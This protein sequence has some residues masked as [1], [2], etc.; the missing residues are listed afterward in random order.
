MNKIYVVGIGPGSKDNL[1]FKAHRILEEADVIVGYTEYVKL[2]KEYLPEKEYLSTPMTKEIDRV[3]LLIKEALSGKKAVMISSG[4]AG[5]YAMAGLV[6]ELAS[7]YDELEVEVVPGVPATHSAAAILG[8]PIIH[9]FAT[10]SLSDLLT[11]WED[12]EKRLEAAASSDFVVSLY[13]PGSKKRKT[14]LKRAA[15]IMLKYRP[16]DT[17]CAYIKRID[18]EGEEFGYITLEDLVSYEADMFTTIIIGKSTTK[19]IKNQMVTARG[20]KI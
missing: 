6:I 14:H 2:V 17:V 18:R 20:Y 3:K 13:N 15:I 8:A 16:K 12:I 10:I 11:P 5:V 9:D 1:T 19:I 4:D 7:K